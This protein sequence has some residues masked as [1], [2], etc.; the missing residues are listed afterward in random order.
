MSPRVDPFPRNGPNGERGGEL[1]AAAR[2]GSPEA[3]SVL[4]QTCR[5]YLLAVGERELTDP[6]R[7]RISPS[8][9]VQ[10]TFL[11]GQQSIAEFDGDTTAEFASWLRGILLNRLAQARRA[12]LLRECRSLQREEP[13]PD[14]SSVVEAPAWILDLETPSWVAMR[15]EEGVTIRAAL[16]R[17]S[18]AHR[19]VIELRNF[20]ALP[21]DE[22]GRI[23][24]RTPGASR[25]LWCR[26]MLC[27][28]RELDATDE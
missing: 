28:K 9:L 21:F 8:D 20:E 1:V 10:E 25:A 24:G 7:R 3:L 16:N 11:V 19:Q 2:G 4:L 5:T 18:A 17:L 6:L 27:L 12:H 26:A 23:V 22:I 13:P 14:L 15:V